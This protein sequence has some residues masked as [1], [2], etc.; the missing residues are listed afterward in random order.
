MKLND[1]K[2]QPVNTVLLE[3]MKQ[4]ALL[5]KSTA[6]LEQ[7]AEN[8]DMLGEITKILKNT[9]STQEEIAKIL[10]EIA[11]L[12]E[13]DDEPNLTSNFK[14]IQHEIIDLNDS[15]EAIQGLMNV[16]TLTYNAAKLFFGF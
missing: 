16:A 15:Q 11:S 2:Y 5:E 10:E 12:K 8:T 6:L 9:Q 14:R 3:S 4:T 7:I 1:V 13:I